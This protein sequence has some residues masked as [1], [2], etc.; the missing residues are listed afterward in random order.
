MGAIDLF[1][2][3]LE[4]TLGNKRGFYIAS[5]CTLD[6]KFPAYKQMI[7]RVWAIDGEYKVLI[8]E[9]SITGKYTTTEEQLELKSKVIQKTFE[10]ILKYYGI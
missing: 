3:A 8:S 9:V 5:G 2:K 7:E 4:N 6:C 1:L 10:N